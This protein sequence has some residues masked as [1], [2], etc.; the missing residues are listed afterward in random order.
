MAGIYIHIPFCKK[1]CYY[2]DF[3]K[4][5]NL[6]LKE[7]FLEALKKE[8]ILQG[9]Y[10]EKE[11]V[12]TIYF[13]GGTPSVLSVDETGLIIDLIAAK[14]SLSRDPEIT[15]EA[16]PEDLNRK[17]LSGLRDTGV[18]RLS[19]GCQ[20]FSD[21]DLVL[22]NRRHNA[23]TS[24]ISVSLADEAGFENI[25][26]DLIYGIPGMS[27]DDWGKNL[28]TALHLPIKHLSA[29]ILTVE[30]G[31]IFAKWVSDGKITMPDDN[32]VVQQYYLLVDKMNINGLIHYEISNF[33]KKGFFSKH[34]ILYW[35]KRKYLGLGP[36]AHS[37]NGE[38]R[39]WNDNDLKNYIAKINQ[40]DIPFK[41]ESLTLEKKYNEY[42]LTSL[43]TMWGIDT[44]YMKKT[45]PEKVISYFMSA[46]EK[47]LQS[48]YMKKTQ[49]H[50]VLTDPGILLSDT[51][52]SEC[53]LAD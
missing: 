8:I 32:L 13:G 47:W 42:I 11:P 23:Y 22:M 51:I 4:T 14:Y 45:F 25:S 2:C 17:Y 31:T 5:G 53:V 10:L 24:A 41:R 6:S 16:N 21:R 46:C 43:R 19:I 30:K 33:A 27:L 29:Y 3:Y 44:V 15:F 39:Q 49:G 12:E 35:K 7:D 40:D 9:N 36:S 37:Y 26:V 34:N 1:I 50:I 20:S 52:M 48:G 28:E 38:T 18:N